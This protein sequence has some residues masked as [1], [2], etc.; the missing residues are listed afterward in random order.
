M[1]AKHVGSELAGCKWVGVPF[2]GGMSELQHIGAS[3]IAVNDKHRHVINLAMVVASGVN[4]A[5][6]LMAMPFHPDVLKYA[7]QHCLE[8][9]RGGWDFSAPDAQL[10]ERWAINYFITQWMGR[11]GDA[12]TDKELKGGISTRWNANGGDSNVRYRGAIKALVTWRTIMRRCSFTTLDCFEFLGKCVDTAGQGLYCDPPWPDD[13]DRYV[14]TFSVANHER[15][16]AKLA[17]Y[18]Y[19]RVV[20]RFG[21][22]P[23]VRK[24]YPTSRWNWRPIEGRT[25]GNNSKAEVLITNGPERASNGLWD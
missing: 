17:S 15:L 13:G 21:D 14:H 6:S 24:L 11:S 23:L 22:H 3:S 10:C 20:I 25:Q 5:K 9:E 7:Q 16:A 2:A 18:E 12:G 4:I 8:M 1:I 19:C